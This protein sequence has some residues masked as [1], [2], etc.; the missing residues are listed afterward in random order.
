MIDQDVFA[1]SPVTACRILNV[2]GFVKHQPN[3]KPEVHI[4]E[5][6][7]QTDLKLEQEMEQRKIRCCSCHKKTLE[8]NYRRLI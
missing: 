8:Q 3:H 6:F 2:R 7:K 1:V 4:P 5:I